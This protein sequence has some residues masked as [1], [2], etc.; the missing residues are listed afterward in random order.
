MGW[1]TAFFTSVTA[2][3]FAVAA[4][5]FLSGALWAFLGLKKHLKRRSDS[6]QLTL[7]IVIGCGCLLL[8][9]CFGWLSFTYAW[10]NYSLARA[11]AHF[12]VVPASAESPVIAP[13]GQGKP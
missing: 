4:I 11:A 6:A 3:C 7:R 1:A 8:G 2:V 12:T 10:M 9:L 13:A 5:L